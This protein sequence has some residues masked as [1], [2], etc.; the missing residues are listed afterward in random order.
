MLNYRKFLSFL[1]PVFNQPVIKLLLAA[2]SL[3]FY[4]ISL[5]LLTTPN[6]HHQPQI[7]PFSESLTG[8]RLSQE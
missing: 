5:D 3:A 8:W 7:K 2:I 6:D 1:V 4:F